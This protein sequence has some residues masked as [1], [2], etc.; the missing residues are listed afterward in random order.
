MQRYLTAHEIRAI[1][2][3]AGLN[4]PELAEYLGVASQ[5]ILLWEN[6]HERVLPE[7]WVC[8]RLRDLAAA[9][10]ERNRQAG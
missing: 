6:E 8:D 10:E 1:R 5:N 3:Q 9:T 7:E 2:E 4:V